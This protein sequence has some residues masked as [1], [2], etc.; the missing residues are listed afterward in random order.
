MMEEQSKFI[1]ESN[2]MKEGDYMDDK[3]TPQ[4]HDM[5]PHL[6]WRNVPDKTKSFAFCIED[7]DAPNGSFYHLLLFN[8]PSERTHIENKDVPGK[9]LTNSWGQTKYK[10]PSPPGKHAHRYFFKVFALSVDKINPHDI[11]S[12]F[13]E[14]SKNKIDEACLMVKYK[15]QSHH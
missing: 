6:T 9:E 2:D 3:F 4:G 1:I 10:G 11:D 7:P 8:I 15:K 14:V 13:K 12:F 5:V